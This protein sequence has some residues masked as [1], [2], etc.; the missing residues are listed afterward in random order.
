LGIGTQL[1]GQ[2][3]A[4]QGMGNV[5]GFAALIFH[6]EGA[7]VGGVSDFPGLIYDRRGINIPDLFERVKRDGMLKAYQETPG[8]VAADKSVIIRDNGDLEI[9]PEGTPGSVKAIKA[10]L[11]LPLNIGVPAYREKQITAEN[12]GRIRFK[13]MVEGANG[14]TTPEADEKLE[15]IPFE[16]HVV[17]GQVLSTFSLAIEKGQSGVLIV[18]DI[19]ANI[20]GVV[21]SYFEWLQNLKGEHW[22]EIAVNKMLEQRMSVSCRDVFAAAEFYKVS[23]RMAATILALERVS[24]AMYAADN[25]LRDRMQK[26]GAL[27]YEGYDLLEHYETIE[28]LNLIC[29]SGRYQELVDRCEAQID[30]EITH[31]AERV[32]KELPA[33]TRRFV[34]ISGP[35]AVGKLNFANRMME[36]LRS[37]HKE[38]GL[39]TYC[40]DIEEDSVALFELISRMDENSILFMYGDYAL[41]DKILA[42]FPAQRT[43]PI[44]LNT[45]PSLKLADN[46]P[47][48]SADLRFLRLIL[49]LTS[50]GS[51]VLEVVKAWTNL[52]DHQIKVVYRNWKNAHATFNAQVGYELP[53]LMHALRDPLEVALLEAKSARDVQSIRLI[54]ELLGLFRGLEGVE[55][56]RTEDLP[57]RST[58][59]QF[60]LRT[61][62][63]LRRSS[64]T[65]DYLRLGRAFSNITRLGVWQTKD[66]TSTRDGRNLPLLKRLLLSFYKAKLRSSHGTFFEITDL[67]VLRDQ[68]IERFTQKLGKNSAQFLKGTLDLTLVRVAPD[69][70]AAM[71][72]RLG[73][74]AYNDNGWVIFDPAIFAR[75]DS[76]AFMRAFG[77]EIG[78][79]Y[80]LEHSDNNILG[81]VA[82][83]ETLS[84]EEQKVLKQIPANIERI[85]KEQRIGR[86]V[87]GAAWRQ[88]S[89]RVIIR[90]AFLQ[91]KLH[92]K[93]SEFEQLEQLSKTSPKALSLEFGLLV[94][95]IFR[96]AERMFKESGFKEV[97]SFLDEWANWFESLINANFVYC[98]NKHQQKLNEDLDAPLGEAFDKINA[99]LSE[100]RVRA[101]DCAYLGLDERIIKTLYLALVNGGYLFHTTIEAVGKAAL[102]TGDFNQPF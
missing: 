101:L 32:L 5:G 88:G 51:S 102:K 81:K 78:A 70:S 99:K 18:P 11:E 89:I 82:A 50:K 45:A 22:S 10:I 77:H 61:E 100:I 6:K 56:L 60:I 3:I 55:L 58:P 98:K 68:V 87:D 41:D 92:K 43:L 76:S 94:R 75:D 23:L 28:E 80:G 74:N 62:D 13:M 91:V 44:F 83:G 67:S 16:K 93:G 57:L 30:R 20:G 29:S 34:A 65:D 90:D 4:V 53:Y 33:N 54:E 38:P 25:P 9:V 52:R 8:F 66:S 49:E 37:M 15:Y 14:P 39:K 95:E 1:K 7:C 27:P 46:K 59:R 96:H 24:A 63:A 35:T 85:F 69:N 84:A 86:P 36:A 64:N 71:F 48:T 12:A 97:E 31:L 21:V 47:F 2:T 26:E 42:L 73:I 19:L 40:I 79:L 72:E 17:D